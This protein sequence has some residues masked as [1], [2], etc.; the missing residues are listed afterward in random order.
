ME[1]TIECM[2]KAERPR[3]R[4][5]TH[6][7]QAL[8][9]RELLALVINTGTAKRSSLDLADELLVR[10]R[11]LRQLADASVEEIMQVKGVGPAKAARLL[12]A[13][14]LG[15][16]LMIHTVEERPRIRSAADVADLSLPRMRDLPREEFVAFLLDTRHRVIETKTISIGH[17]NASLVHPRELFREGVRRSAAAMI[18]AHNH[19]SGDPEPSAE[20]VRLTHRLQEAGELLGISVLDHVIIGDN[21][22]VSMRERGFMC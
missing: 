6:G 13:L 14:E 19:P 3:E 9:S 16:R 18:L 11:D 2:P 10:W 4:L 17:L 15:R 21:K 1:T 22:Y 7:P 12:A 5:L 8:S 20:D